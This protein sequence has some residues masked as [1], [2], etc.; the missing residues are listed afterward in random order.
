MRQKPLFSHRA[1]R[2][3]LFQPP[4][5]AVCMYPEKTVGSVSVGMLDFIPLSRNP[6]ELIG[7]GRQS[8]LQLNYIKAYFDI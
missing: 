7:M 2:T 4:R 6:G 1:N 3:Q 5:R 8:S